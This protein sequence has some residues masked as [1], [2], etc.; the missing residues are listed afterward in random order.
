MAKKV[1]K[2]LKKIEW[3][4]RKLSVTEDGKE[5][6]SKMIA[7]CGFLENE[8]GQFSG[9]GVA[10]ADS[11]ETLGVDQRTR[12]N[13]LGAKEKARRKKCKVRF[14]LLKKNKAFQKELH[15]GGCQEAVTSGYVASK[16]VESLSSGDVSHGGVKI[17][18]T[19]GSC[20]GPKSTISL[21]LFMEACVFARTPPLLPRTHSH[22]HTLSHART[23]NHN[24]HNNLKPL[25][26]QVDFS[27]SC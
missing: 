3:K 5:G 1:M 21:S 26:S 13:R 10:S 25:G 15:E 14:S 27:F 22:T 9:E 2:K 16:N 20:S 6:K 8:L 23:L 19:D 11:V 4:G 7:S 12:V 24:N 17:E 18:E